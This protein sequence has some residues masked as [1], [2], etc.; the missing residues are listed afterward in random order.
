MASDIPRNGPLHHSIRWSQAPSLPAQFYQ[1]RI[2]TCSHPSLYKSKS[3]IKTK[4]Q[5]YTI[6]KS[7][8]FGVALPDSSRQS[9]FPRPLS[10]Y[11]TVPKR[12]THHP[13]LA[14]NI[15]S[16]PQLV[17]SFVHS[18][19]KYSQWLGDILLYSRSQLACQIETTASWT[20]AGLRCGWRGTWLDCCAKWG[21]S[22]SW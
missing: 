6:P 11:P 5:D 3:Y 19:W 22:E 15:T 14:W 7:N 12:N 13:L 17:T 8:L 9:K 18:R 20:S 1:K 2:E 21:L 10:F 4:P 16:T